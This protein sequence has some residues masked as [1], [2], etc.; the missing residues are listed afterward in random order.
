MTKAT[1]PVAR[2]TF[3]CVRERGSVRPIIITVS[4][5][6]V[7]VRLKGCRM[8]YTVTMDQLY[9]MGAENA[10]NQRRRD[11]LAAKKAERKDSA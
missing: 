9:R 3:S 5:T 11:K 2:E 6:F 8:S 4:A 10:A 7:S 1:R